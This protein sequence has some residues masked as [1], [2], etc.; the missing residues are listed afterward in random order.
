MQEDAMRGSAFEI[1][2]DMFNNN[3]VTSC[4][5]GYEL[6]CFIYNNGYV[7]ASDGK[8]LKSFYCIVI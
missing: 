7:W 8:L 2:K 5:L 1:S 6:P 4:K 3:L